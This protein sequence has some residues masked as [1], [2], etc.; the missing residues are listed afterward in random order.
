MGQELT[1]TFHSERWRRGMAAFASWF[2]T[3]MYWSRASCW[4]GDRSS[5]AVEGSAMVKDLD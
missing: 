4:L 3:C 5:L 1:W 2:V